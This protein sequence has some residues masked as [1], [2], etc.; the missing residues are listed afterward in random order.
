MNRFTVSINIEVHDFSRNIFNK[1]MVYRYVQ[2]DETSSKSFK[3]EGLR[4]Q[5]KHEHDIQYLFSK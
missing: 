3:L 4:A 2:F 5:G 1:P